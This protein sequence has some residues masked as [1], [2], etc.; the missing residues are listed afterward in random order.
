MVAVAMIRN[1]WD[2]LESYTVYDPSGLACDIV[3]CWPPT[4]EWISS[5]T[6]GGYRTA[7]A[8]GQAVFEARAAVR[9]NV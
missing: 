9:E 2:P 8:A 7:K 4:G 3:F 5:A 1:A 6:K